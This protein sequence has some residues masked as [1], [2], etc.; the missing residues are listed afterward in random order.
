MLEP[1]D[2]M[3]EVNDVPTAEEIRAAMER[4]VAS[5]GFVRSPQLVAF[6]RFV[7]ESTLCGDTVHI[8]SY[9]IG[10]EA[11]G[12]GERFDPQIDPIVRVEAARLRKALAS[13]FAGQGAGSPVTIEIPLGRYVPRFG[14]RKNY[15]PIAILIALLRGALRTIRAPSRATGVRLLT[16]SV[17]RPQRRVTGTGIDRS[18]AG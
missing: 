12:R 1:S 6:L 10:V 15:R 18:S 13:F 3:N 7:V 11:L 16:S 5:S 4:I 9:T 8:K 17:R 2:P 14:R